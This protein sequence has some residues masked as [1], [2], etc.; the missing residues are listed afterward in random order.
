MSNFPSL[1][2]GFEAPL[3][4][5]TMSSFLWPVKFAISNRCRLI[6][7]YSL[8][9]LGFSACGVLDNPQLVKVLLNLGRLLLLGSRCPEGVAGLWISGGC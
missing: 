3:I 8:L 2:A 4:Q 7:T 1:S 9:K 5:I 6:L